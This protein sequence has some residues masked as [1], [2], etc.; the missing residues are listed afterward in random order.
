MMAE[1][2]SQTAERLPEAGHAAG[3]APAGPAPINGASAPTTASARRPAR[4]RRSGQEVAPRQELRLGHRRT[5]DGTDLIA[6]LKADA[7]T[8]VELVLVPR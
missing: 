6:W 4:I 7:T 3:D 2:V 1:D 8:P 5:L